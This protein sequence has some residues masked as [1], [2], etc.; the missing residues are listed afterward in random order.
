MSDFA[1]VVHVGS[2][3]SA[4]P[5]VLKVQFDSGAQQRGAL[6]YRTVLRMWNW[7]IDNQPF[8]ILNAI[9]TFLVGKGGF[10]SFTWTPPEGTE[11][12]VYCDTWDWTYSG[13]TIV[14]I[15]GTFEEK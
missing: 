1:Y 5:R 11:V 15:H 14:G 7:R 9:H 13:G 2:G 4:K 6:G 3:G 8:S 12:S 10:T